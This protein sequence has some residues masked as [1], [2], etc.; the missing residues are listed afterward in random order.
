MIR[1]LVLHPDKRLRAMCEPVTAVTPAVRQLMDDLA[2]TMLHNDR[3]VGL[4]AP[5]IGVTERVI[6]VDPR[7]GR[8]E[9][10]GSEL[11]RLLLMAN[12]EV[13]WA[14]EETKSFNE[15]CLSIPEMYGDV[16]RPA[17]IRVRYLDRDGNEQIFEDGGFPAIVIQHEIDHLNGVL[18]IDHLSNLKRDMLLRRYYKMLKAEG[19]AVE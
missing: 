14:S 8:G 10:D 19:I 18:F 15:G 2:E 3:G 7:E 16:S 9:R 6:V 4:A 12:P 13:I 11:S 5:Q 1:D 17:A